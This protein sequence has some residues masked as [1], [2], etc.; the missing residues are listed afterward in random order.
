MGGSLGR[1][2]AKLVRWV[3]K[4]VRWVAKLVRWLANSEIGGYVGNAPANLWVRI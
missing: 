2:V 1:W 3:A 4:L